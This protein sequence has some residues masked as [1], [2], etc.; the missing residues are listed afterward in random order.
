VGLCLEAGIDEIQLRDA[1]ILGVNGTEAALI[2]GFVVSAASP[3][4]AS[5]GTSL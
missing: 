5:S 3:T 1:L 4:A 2:R